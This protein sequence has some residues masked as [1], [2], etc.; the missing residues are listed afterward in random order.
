MLVSLFGF[1]LECEGMDNHRLFLNYCRLELGLSDHTV[2]SYGLIYDI[3]M[4][5][6]RSIL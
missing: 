3:L 4:K 6:A 1:E 2:T 5:P